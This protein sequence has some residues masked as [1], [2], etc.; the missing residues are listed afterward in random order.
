MHQELVLTYSGFCGQVQLPMP[1]LSSTAESIRFSQ[2]APVQRKE[3]WVIQYLHPSS[4]TMLSS[5]PQPAAQEYVL[6]AGMF[7]CSEPL[8][9]FVASLAKAL[10]EERYATLPPGEYCGCL[11]AE[12]N[13]WFF[14]TRSSNQTIF[15]TRS[16]ES[17]CWSTNPRQIVSVQNLDEEALLWCCTGRD[18]FVYTG[19]EYVAA[20]TVVRINATSA[21]STPFEQITPLIHSQR[22][23]IQELATFCYE[24]LREATRPLASTK[25]KIGVL[26]SGGIDSSAIATALVHNGADVVAYHFH[27]PG[28]AS[29]LAD[30]QAVCQMLCIPLVILQVSNGSDYLSEGWR[31]SHP[32]NHA[33][34]R[35]FEQVADQASQDGVMLMTTGR[36]GD[37]S[38]GPKLS[39]GLC[40]IF[41][42]PIAGREKLS[43]T[44]GA[45][46]TDWLLPSLIKSVWR[47]S[48][49]INESSLAPTTANPYAVRAA[50]FFRRRSLHP[51]PDSNLY[52]VACFSP[53]DLALESTIW[54]PRGICVTHPYHHIAVQRLVASIPSAYRLLP[55]RGRK[56]VKP[57]LRWAFAGKLPPCAVRQG[58]GPWL[59]APHQDYCIQQASYLAQLIGSPTSQVLQRGIVDPIQLRQVLEDQQMLRAHYKAIIA[60]A[61]TELYLRQ[62]DR[63]NEYDHT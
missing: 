7:F 55:Y 11:V 40:D 1:V 16:H 29:E 58:R 33:G 39:Y 56:V 20:G 36:G 53:Q 57:V 3:N 9:S 31:F 24:A 15:Y 52:D 22:V 61:M 63:E 34:L 42:A 46:S 62:F 51:P 54:Q 26:L 4:H 6:L 23:T 30:A 12:E 37:P 41:S 50:P 2:Y 43:M 14:K 60:T 27:F 17:V 8:H 18:T 59:S 28:A 48:S 5:L 21:Q 10:K 35:W 47:S 13:I 32:Y 49:L 45:L 19:V 38:F 25:R 44:A